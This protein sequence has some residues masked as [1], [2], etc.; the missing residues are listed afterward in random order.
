MSDNIVLSV[1]SILR[2]LITYLILYC[3]NISPYL[4]IIFIMISDFIDVDIP[5]MLGLYNNKYIGRTLKYQMIDKIVDTIVY[6]LLLIYTLNQ[7]YLSMNEKYILIGLFIYRLVGV[8]MF[9]KTKDRQYLYHYPNFYL[10]IMLA[11]YIF[12]AFSVDS[13]IRIYLILAVVIYKIIT[14]YYHHIINPL[15]TKKYK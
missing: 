15:S 13:N 7:N 10:E 11:F 2:I 12:N 6:L 3:T 5:R 9:I 4:K 8:I 1:S 14:E